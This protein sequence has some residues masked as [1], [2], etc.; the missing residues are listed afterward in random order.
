MDV[1]RLFDLGAQAL[2][3][4]LGDRAT[5][6][7][8]GIDADS[9]NLLTQ[10]QPW[11]PEQARRVTTA[12]A[13]VVSASLTVAGIPAVPLPG[14]YVAVVI[15]R[16][17]SPCNRITA[18]MKAPDTF[19]AMAASGLANAVE[20][21]DTPREQMIGL[22]MAYSSGQVVDLAGQ[23]LPAMIEAEV[24]KAIEKANRKRSRKS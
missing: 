1:L 17:V 18:A 11:T 16:T 4:D 15:A 10:V 19:D 14:Q 13:D 23:A 5:A 7:Q 24:E 3:R 9:W 12:L 6:L 22:V 20:I 21:K 8:Y 2:T